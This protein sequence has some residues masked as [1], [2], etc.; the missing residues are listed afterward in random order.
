MRYEKQTAKLTRALTGM[1]HSQALHMARTRD[2]ERRN[3]VP[4]AHCAHQRAF[5]ARLTFALIDAFPDNLQPPGAPWGIAAVRADTTSLDILPAAGICDDLLAALLPYHDRAYGGIR[6]ASGTR[7]TNTDDGWWTLHDLDTGAQVRVAAPAPAIPHRT[8]PGVATRACRLITAPRLTREE[9]RDLSYFERLA[10][11]SPDGWLEHRNVLG[12]RLLRRPGLIR[13]IAEVHGSA[14]IY[15]HSST[16]V[17]FEWCCGPSSDDIIRACRRAGV[18]ADLAGHPLPGTAIDR[19]SDF[20]ARLHVGRAEL[21]LR[22]NKWICP[23][24]QP[25]LS[26]Q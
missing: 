8:R 15:S 9:H 20:S 26:A 7:V 4:D 21:Y 1:S 14:N 16:D 11:S 19:G 10:Q 17:V 3:P 23:G 2:C 18:T 24:E 13:T 22:H 6:G 25:E 12:S 5:E